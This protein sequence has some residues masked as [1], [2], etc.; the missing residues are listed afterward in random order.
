MVRE[1]ES[2]KRCNSE[3][4]LGSILHDL[5]EDMDHVSGAIRTSSIIEEA[6]G[7]ECWI[8]MARWATSLADI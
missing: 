2:P 5:G 3:V 6:S 8:N 4:D 7:W 1:I